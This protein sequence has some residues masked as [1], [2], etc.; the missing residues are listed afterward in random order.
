MSYTVYVWVEEKA[1]GKQVKG[2]KES[3]R[4]SWQKSLSSLGLSR[5][6]EKKE[7]WLQKSMEKRRVVLLLHHLS[8]CKRDG[9]EMDDLVL[10]LLRHKESHSLCMTWLSN[11]PLLCSLIQF[12]SVVKKELAMDCVPR[13]C[14]KMCDDAVLVVLGEEFFILW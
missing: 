6:S 8:S 13:H 7:K 10:C 2:K 14:I 11:M 4:L 1:V 3:H 5:D 12:L 9:K